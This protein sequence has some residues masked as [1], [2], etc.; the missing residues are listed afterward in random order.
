MLLGEMDLPES[1]EVAVNCLLQRVDQEHNLP[2]D[3]DLIS[4]AEKVIRYLEHGV[5]D[6]QSVDT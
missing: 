2:P 3:I 1:V 4:E 6:T 5:R